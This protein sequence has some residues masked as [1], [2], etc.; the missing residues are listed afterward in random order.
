[1]TH[2]ETARYNEVIGLQIGAVQEIAHKLNENLALEELE[3][4]IAELEGA[5]ADLKGS[6]AAMPHKRA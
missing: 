1:M 4:I 6:L 3:A 2:I 5:I